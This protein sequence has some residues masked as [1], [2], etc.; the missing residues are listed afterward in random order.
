M[1]SLI[2]PVD[3]DTLQTNAPLAAALLALNNTHASELSWLT[4]EA[5]AQLLDR[6]WRAWTCGGYALMIALDE[7]T[8][9]DNPNHRW[10]RAR[11]DRF[12]YVDRIVVAQA[13]R[14]RGL[15]RRL[16]QQLIQEA[17]AAGHDRLVC[18]INL[19]PPNPESDAF[20]AALGFAPLATASIHGGAKTV[21]YM[22]RSV[23]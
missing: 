4:P 19:D 23:R 6:A 20:H 21:R 12:V 13:A 9:Y 5:L 11:Y 8:N 2:T 15:A 17:I 16:Y 22:V 10:F 7:T 18:E 14:G 1:T 3:A